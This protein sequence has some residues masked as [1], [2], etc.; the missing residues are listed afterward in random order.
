VED[1]GALTDAP[2][3]GSSRGVAAIQLPAGLGYGLQITEVGRWYGWRGMA[4]ARDPSLGRPSKASRPSYTSSISVSVCTHIHTQG[5]WCVRVHGVEEEVGS[6]VTLLG[7]P[8][9]NTSARAAQGRLNADADNDKQKQKQ[10]PCHPLFDDDDAD[11]QGGK[12]E[13]GEGAS[14]HGHHHL[15]QPSVR[16]CAWQ[17]LLN[18]GLLGLL[19]AGNQQ[20][21][22][23]TTAR[24][25]H[26][27]TGAI[28]RHT[29]LV[30]YPCITW[31]P[32]P[33]PMCTIFCLHVHRIARLG[34]GAAEAHGR[35]T[36]R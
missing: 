15:S 17:A 27:T 34:P 7:D 2:C 21:P 3:V 29:H 22:H 30:M 24:W 19:P 4:A 8:S 12:V 6:L 23:P 25:C 1:L 26:A 16:R 13:E 14:P 18:G 20:P 10:E 36:N 32:E 31:P 35:C 11:D 33:V 28:R 9:P 5:A